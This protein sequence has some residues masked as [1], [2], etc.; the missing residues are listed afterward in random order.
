MTAPQ[1]L[2]IDSR[3][4][5][6]ELLTAGLDPSVVVVMLN[7]Q[8]TGLTQIARA[9]QGYENVSTVNVISHGGPGAL[10]LGSGLVTTAS[11]A[12][13]STALDSIRA[14]LS[15]GAD[16]LLYGCD[17]AAGD[18]GQ[19][20]IQA[21]A[22]ATGADVAASLDATGGAN[23]S[24]DWS[25]ESATGPI[26]SESIAP[27]DYNHDLGYWGNV[28]LL[29]GDRWAINKGTQYEII[30]DA[31]GGG[32][33]S[34]Y[35]VANN[36]GAYNVSNL[37]TSAYNG[38][39][40]AIWYKFTG[41][42]NAVPGSPWYVSNWDPDAG[43][44][45]YWGAYANATPWQLTGSVVLTPGTSQTLDVSNLVAD[46]YYNAANTWRYFIGGYASQAIAGAVTASSFTV[47]DSTANYA[48][49]SAPTRIDWK[50]RVYL[51]SMTYTVNDGYD[52]ARSG[53]LNPD[54]YSAY[55]RYKSATYTTYV[56]ADYANDGITW[57][58]A[59]ADQV[60]VAASRSSYNFG[61]GAQDPDSADRVTGYS[62]VGIEEKVSGSYTT[63]TSTLPA[64]L[65]L[66][67][68]TFY[69]DNL[70]PEYAGKEFRITV[71]AT[72]SDGTTINKTF[73][74]TTGTAEQVND[75]PTSAGNTVTFNEDSA[76]TVSV[77]R[78]PSC[79]RPDCGRY[80][81]GINCR[82]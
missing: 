25:L 37:F 7:D 65:K 14:S 42:S 13:E 74:L 35:G 12:S 48:T 17:V 28:S 4:P 34:K 82:P 9:L 39:W 76:F 57:T 10:A 40:E 20:F 49:F 53:S 38:D 1:F 21:L 6:P 81:E 79:I 24:S 72:S 2:F 29:S 59:P 80:C 43:G 44:F 32:K 63:L 50:G 56:Y 52:F 51:G 27:T 36:V 41:S 5:Q 64:W 16:L 71:R 62:F 60:W 33:G 46:D 67:G 45:T 75:A 18:E 70:A 55:S 22:A 26:E 47:G 11:L 31:D 73:T 78:T 15:E 69:V 77:R 23:A 30:F 61:R 68:T 19:R 66:S 58:G 3:V 54:Y 8:E